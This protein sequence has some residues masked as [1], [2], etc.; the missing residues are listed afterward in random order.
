[1]ADVIRVDDVYDNAPGDLAATDPMDAKEAQWHDFGA[2]ATITLL[3]SATASRV[4]I[5]FILQD[6]V[7]LSALVCKDI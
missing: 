7:L 2:L 6:Q 1:M 5:S 4:P 3:T